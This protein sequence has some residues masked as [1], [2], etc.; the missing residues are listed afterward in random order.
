MHDDHEPGISLLSQPIDSVLGRQLSSRARRFVTEYGDFLGKIDFRDIV[1]HPTPQVRFMEGYYSTDGTRHS[2]WLS[3]E[4]PDFEGLLI[5]QSMRAI[6][7]EG[8]F[9]RAECEPASVSCS[10]IHY[11]GVLLSNVVTGPVIDMQLAQRGFYLYDRETLIRR[12]IADLWLDAVQKTVAPGFLFRKWALFTVV[13]RLDPTFAGDGAERLRRLIREEFP[14][15]VE[16]G[17]RF[18]GTIIETGFKDPYSALI[19]MVRLRNALELH[20]KIFI[21]D[22]NGTSW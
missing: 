21:V 5:H 1:Q 10:L 20:E 14:L 17:D 11:L 16:F 22:G 9:P 3:R 2:V 4:S 8:G 12:A 7:M 18:S 13:L 15:S 6:L 19:V